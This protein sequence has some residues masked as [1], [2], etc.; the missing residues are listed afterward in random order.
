MAEGE[1]VDWRM[2]RRSRPE[3]WGF[4][5]CDLGVPHLPI[6]SVQLRVLHILFMFIVKVIG[7]LQ[8]RSLVSSCLSYFDINPSAVSSPNS[9]S[10]LWHTVL[11]HS[12][13]CDILLELPSYSPLDLAP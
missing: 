5:Q 7:C 12:P 1:D 8:L 10:F 4:L 3:R 6:D 13:G 11:F 9:L 2:R